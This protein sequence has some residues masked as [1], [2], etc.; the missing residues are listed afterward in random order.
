[1]QVFQILALTLRQEFLIDEVLQIQM[2][3][4]STT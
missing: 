4:S 1:M 3:R 2:R